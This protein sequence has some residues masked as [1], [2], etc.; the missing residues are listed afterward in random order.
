MVF[1]C[2][3]VPCSA[4]IHDEE[5]ER[6]MRRSKDKSDYTR[7]RRHRSKSRSRSK[8][9][10][11]IARKK[12]KKEELEAE[13][14]EYDSRESEED[15]EDD[16][17]DDVSR[18]P[19]RPEFRK[20]MPEKPNE[21]PC[22]RE[23]AGSV[24]SDRH[25]RK[26]SKEAQV[27]F[28]EQK[29]D[30]RTVNTNKSEALPGSL[31]KS[32]LADSFYSDDSLENGDLTFEV[33]YGTS[34]PLFEAL[35]LN[36]WGNVLFFLRAG[37]FIAGGTLRTDDMDDPETQVR[38]WVH[39][40]DDRGSVMWR[41][42]PLHAAI[43]LAAPLVVVQRLVEVYPDALACQD[44][45]GNLPLNLAAKLHGTESFVFQVV[46][47]KSQRWLQSR[48]DTDDGEDV[49]T[50]TTE[51]T[52]SAV[53][54][55]GTQG[56]SNDRPMTPL[57]SPTMRPLA[58]NGRDDGWNPPTFTQTPTARPVDSEPK[59][60]NLPQEGWENRS[61]IPT[62]SQQPV[63]TRPTVVDNEREERHPEI[64]SK[65][66]PHS[67]SI[68][69]NARDDWEY[70][71]GTPTNLHSRGTSIVEHAHD[72]GWEFRPGTPTKQNRSSAFVRRLQES[73]D[74][75][76]SSSDES[77]DSEYKQL[78]NGSFGDDDAGFLDDENEL[79]MYYHHG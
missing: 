59:G 79:E 19:H 64:L 23:T 70:R 15:E 71:P 16:Y 75:A 37:K 7:W 3:L 6:A 72:E 12:K 13:A 2:C 68:L 17:D 31:P 34:T 5:F 11:S 36:D 42:L 26:S 33:D 41:Q 55:T 65:T 14:R 43:C 45:F 44:S 25:S 76:Y 27:I 32:I 4:Q 8:R 20:P 69:E 9:D 47:I 49:T 24:R 1:N 78:C 57:A 67:S 10:K 54:S 18:S 60:I 61:G 39:C 62:N 56:P 21:S 53:P 46:S 66:Q 52:G 22:L 50:V 29:E 73:F 48:E 28:R 40:Q 63:V 38:T 74:A 30:D 51:R 77:S 58:E 35:E